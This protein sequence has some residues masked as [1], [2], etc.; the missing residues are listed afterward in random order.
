MGHGN[1]GQQITSMKKTIGLLALLSA[2][3]PLS[4]D[5]YLAAIP[6]LVK[7]W[8]ES[9]VTVNLT[10]VCFF[11]SYCAFLLIYGPVSDRFGRKLPLLAGIGLYVVACIFCAMAGNIVIMIVARTV[12]GAG[13]AAATAM[14]LAISKDLFEGHIRQRIFVQIGIIVAAAP[15][16]A[17]VLGGWVIKLYSWRL[18]FII[19][20]LMGL[21]ALF[22]V[23]R[24][25][26]SLKIPVQDRFSQVFGSYIRLFGNVSYILLA[27][28]F[29]VSGIPFFA[30]IACSTDIYI[31]SLGYNEQ[32]FGY[33]F[34]L[35]AAAFMIAPVFFSR[36]SR[37][38]SLI[39][40]LTSG[41]TGMI[42]AA[43]LMLC[44][45]I[46]SPWRLALP[47]WLLTFSFSFCRPP[48]NNLILEQV[49]RD[50]GAASSFMVFIFFITGASSMGMISLNWK[51]KITALGWMGVIASSV[52][53]LAW[54][55]INRW[56]VLRQPV[57]PS[58]H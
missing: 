39:P 49:D 25:S 51:D 33:F 26:E 11:V 41:F 30:F 2:F 46:P 58:K 32:Q 10:L 40:L 19:Q 52:T 45:W 18:V 16:I 44:S 5:M 1:I 15:M 20:A 9:L 35:N 38:F 48:S 29:A 24:M 56:V 22:G 12:Q 8:Q 47:M 36:M 50:I 7:D 34:G 31:A 13:A 37:R 28:T 27:L 23:Y 17:P 4:T 43:T 57:Q 14:A 6:L 21:V 55:T 42:G 3:P 54:L 53:L